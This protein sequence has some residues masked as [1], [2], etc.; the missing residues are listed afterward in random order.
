[1]TVSTSTTLSSAALWR[2]RG[3][4]LALAALAAASVVF[5][6]LKLSTSSPVPVDVAAISTPDRVQ[7]ADT[8]AVARALG[9]SRAGDAAPR[10]LPAQRWTLSGVA[11][12]GTSQGVALIASEGQ[13]AKP[14]RVKARLEE[15]LFLVG[16]EPRKAH[17]GPTPDGPVSVTLELPPMRA[18]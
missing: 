8:D 15:G 12:A 10:G 1:M 6:V 14:Y 18:R 16:L 13:A 4:T 17:L 2:L 9:A 5:W 7:P 11:R 3:V